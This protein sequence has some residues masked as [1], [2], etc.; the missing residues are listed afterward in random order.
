MHT[1]QIGDL[2]DRTTGALQRSY[3]DFLPPCFTC[4]HVLP[5]LG[6]HVHS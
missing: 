5:Q 6:I 3:G 4:K 2:Y 1:R